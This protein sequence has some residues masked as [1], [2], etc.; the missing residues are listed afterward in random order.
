MKEKLMLAITKSIN[1]LNSIRAYYYYVMKECWLY[2]RGWVRSDLSILLY[3]F[4]Y[5]EAFEFQRNSCGSV[6]FQTSTNFGKPKPA[7]Q[8]SFKVYRYKASSNLYNVMC[9]IIQVEC[10]EFKSF[11]HSESR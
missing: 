2:V 1:A 11:Y 7:L 3:N 9:F 6:P 4:M 8:N 10:I 5:L